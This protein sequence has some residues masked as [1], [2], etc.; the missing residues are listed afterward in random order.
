[1]EKE[2][3][4][5]KGKRK[6]AGLVFLNLLLILGVGAFVAVKL[7]TVEEVI[8]EGSELYP[9]EAIEGWL[10]NDEY[11]WNS[12]YVFF[13]YK[14]QEPEYLAF[15]DS[16]DVSLEPPHTLKVIVHEKELRGRIYIDSMGQNAYFDK[17]G[18]VVEMS[19]EEIEGV[20]K[21]TGMDVEQIV[22]NEKL[23]IKGNSVLKN[24]LSLTQILK[25]YEMSPKSI[26]YGAEGTYT[27]KFGKISVRLGQAE[28]FND[29]ISRLSKILPRLDGQKG[30]LHLESWSENTK[31]ITFE[32]S[33]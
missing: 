2:R 13:K 26:K 17:E 16:A 5:R 27:L 18:T 3:R 22:L 9:D 11:S 8:I 12:L 21:I 7:F 15:V 19:S 10:L 29:K 32:K 31:D 20:P 24:L 23:P 30:T 4:R 25:K 33:N 14:L 28:D 1:M 6:A